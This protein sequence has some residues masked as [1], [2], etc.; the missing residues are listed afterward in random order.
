MNMHSITPSAQSLAS[1]APGARGRRPG[2]V[3]ERL[4]AAADRLVAEGQVSAITARDIARAAG[5]S[6]GALYHHFE[7][8]HGLVLAALL[9]RYGR[10]V[11]DF[12][13]EVA[14]VRGADPPTQMTETLDRL[15]TAALEL[16]GAALPMFAHVLSEPVLFHRFMAAVHSPPFGGRVFMDPFVE[17]LHAEREGGHLGEVSPAAAADLLVGAV[18]LT[19]LRDIMTPRSGADRKQAARGLVQAIVLGLAP[20]PPVA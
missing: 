19:A 13:A 3:R 15:T 6:D 16:Q 4:L 7:D 14:A 9:A 11:G 20:R 2:R 18:L 17:Y 10:L 5:V 12:E 8:K 1:T